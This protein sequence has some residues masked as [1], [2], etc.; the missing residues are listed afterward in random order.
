MRIRVI[1]RTLAGLGVAAA[2]SALAVPGAGAQ[3]SS[4]H[5]ADDPCAVRT[6]ELVVLDGGAV[7]IVAGEDG[8]GGFD[9]LQA[10]GIRW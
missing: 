1:R 3:S 4:W 6:V 9:Q 2:V 5:V 7:R 8:C 10:R